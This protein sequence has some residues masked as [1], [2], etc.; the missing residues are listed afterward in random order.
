MKAGAI[1]GLLCLTLAFSGCGDERPNGNS[2]TDL[3]ESPRKAP[4]GQ[5]PGSISFEVGTKTVK[6][7]EP[8]LRAPDR[9]PPDSLIVEDLIEGR[10]ARAEVGDELTVEYIGIYYNGQRFTNSWDRAKPFEFELG[11]GTT[12]VNPGWEKGLRQMRIGGRRKLIIPPQLLYPGGALPGS[13]P[14]DTLV[15]VIDLVGID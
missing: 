6:R 11:A 4:A 13:E 7:S 10:G 3:V 8:E 1:A 5:V 2:T 9:P 14:E 12:M 15:Y